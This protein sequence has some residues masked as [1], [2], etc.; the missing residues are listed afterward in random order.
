ME[1]ITLNS[2][3][4]LPDGLTYACNPGGCE[5]LK[6]TTG[7]MIIQGTPAASN[8]VKKYPIT[9]NFTFTTTEFGS[10]DLTFPDATIAPGVYEI[11]V[12]AQGDPGCISSTKD[13]QFNFDHNAFVNEGL[14]H[15]IL[16]I[17]SKEVLKGDFEIY[18]LAGTLMSKTNLEI[19]H[20]LNEY[21]IDINTLKSGAYFYNIRSGKR[22]ET[23]KILIPGN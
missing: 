23:G 21:N 3:G 1:K 2:I 5:M 12:L 16:Q 9:L 19:F 8:T 10:L 14:D 11:D 22:F 13:L 20:G 6:N 7:C 18:N 15:L 4:G 17:N